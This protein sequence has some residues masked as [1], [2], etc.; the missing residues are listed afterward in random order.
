MTA[1]ERS[2]SMLDEIHQAPVAARR[3]TTIAAMAIPNHFRW[4]TRVPYGVQH[5]GAHGEP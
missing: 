3:D 2:R 4:A 5:D 1:W